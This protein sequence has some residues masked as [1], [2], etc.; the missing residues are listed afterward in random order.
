MR[1]F[2]V[3]IWIAVLFVLTCTSSLDQ[4]FDH[5]TVSFHVTVN[6]NYN[7]L[8]LL[9]DARFTEPYWLFV[10]F[11]HFMCFALLQI[12]LFHL[13]GSIKRSCSIAIFI[14]LF[15]EILQLYFMRDGRA[16]DLLIDSLGILLAAGIY[17]TMVSN[18]NT[19]RT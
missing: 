8:L 9:S 13:T 3:V 4:L 16:V 10:K 2:A 12:L 19:M 17:R 14:A 15:T 18:V 1:L 5:Q 6:P 7:E 11:G